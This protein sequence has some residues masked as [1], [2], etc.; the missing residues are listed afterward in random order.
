[1]TSLSVRRTTSLTKQLGEPAWWDQQDEVVRS[2]VGDLGV[3][4][5][6]G[7]TGEAASDRPEHLVAEGE[8]A[9]VVERTEALEVVEGDRHGL[10]AREAA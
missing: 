6:R 4:H 2:Q 7:H 3:E 5:P 8:A 10:V 9:E 1:M